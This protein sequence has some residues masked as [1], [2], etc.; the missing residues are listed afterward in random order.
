[1]S[2]R[3][4]DGYLS[5][6]NDAVDVPILQ[7]Q[8]EQDT[9]KSMYAATDAD[10][11]VSLIDYNRAGVALVE[12]VSAPVLRTPEQAGAYVRK[13]RQL[14]RHVGAS[15]GNMNEG[16]LRCDVNVSI[17]RINEPFG[18]RCEI[19]NLNSVKFMMHAIDYEIRRQFRELSQGRIIEPSTLGFNEATGETY[20]QRQKEEMLDYRFMPE[21][22]VAPLEISPERIE[23]LNSSLPEMPD[24]RHARLRE[25]YGLSIRDVNVLTR[26]NAEDDASEITVLGPEHAGRTSHPN[27]VDYFEALVHFGCEPQVAA[28]WTIHLLPK[29]LGQAKLTFS[30]NPIG[31]LALAELLHILEEQVITRTCESTTSI[32]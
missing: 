29:Y 26:L 15:D 22:N 6:P 30:L 3:F 1:M 2:I 14:L 32:H 25:Q 13:L 21:P 19:K 5:T 24:A 9:G 28:N 27:A 7:L 12:I 11:H 17:H 20:V 16:S 8:L 18:T 23:A 10:S 4:E 31:P